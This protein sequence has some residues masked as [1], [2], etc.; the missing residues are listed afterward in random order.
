MFCDIIAASGNYVVRENVCKMAFSVKGVI[1]S[2][3]IILDE[4]ME[5]I[6]S[7]VREGSVLADI[8][9]DHGKLPVFLALSGKIRRA[10]AC[11]INEK[12]LKK[13]VALIKKNNL[14]NVIDTF[15]TDGLCGVEKYSPTDIV[16]AGMGGELI[17]EILDGDSFKDKEKMY[18]L[19]PMTKESVLREYLYSHGFTIVDEH[20]VRAGKIYQI[21]CVKYTGNISRVTPVEALLGKSNIQK[22]GALFVE[23]LEKVIDRQTVKCE[24]RE[25][26]GLDNT[27]EEGV[28]MAL[29]SL[30]GEYENG[31]C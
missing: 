21:I 4:R 1:K 15:L 8:G 25:R 2:E 26:A 22:G 17:C 6:A 14:E 9:T 13:A 11:D 12:P 16:I 29:C 18:I 23:L 5:C 24:G 27:Y 28:L 31:E 19:Q 7:C 10:V 3:K 30:K 20:L